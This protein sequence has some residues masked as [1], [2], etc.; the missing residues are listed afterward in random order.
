MSEASKRASAK[1]RARPEIAERRRTYTKMRRVEK[2]DFTRW[3]KTQ[4]GCVDCG[5][6]GHPV[7][8]DFDHRP[9]TVKLSSVAALVT[10]SWDSIIAEI[11]KCDVVCANCH[12]IRTYERLAA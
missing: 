3:V 9:G 6:K 4:R 7:A 8:L 12:R 2:Q 11:K 5:Y 1:Y 10:C